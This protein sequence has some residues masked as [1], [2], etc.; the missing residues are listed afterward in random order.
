VLDWLNQNGFSLTQGS[1]NR[2][3]LTVS[4]TR[5]Q[6]EHAFGVTIDDYLM[7]T[8]QFHAIDTDPSIPAA[9]APW[10]R[11]VTGFSNLAR[12]RPALSP[13]TIAQAYNGTLT[14]G[15]A[16]PGT[17]S[18]VLPPGI[19]GAGQT[20]AVIEYDSF[21]PSDV[22]F[23]LAQVGLP[24]TL[25]NQ[26]TTVPVSKGTSPSGCSIAVANYQ[27]TYDP[28]IITSLSP[29]VGAQIGGT[30]VDLMGT[31][32]SQTM[33][34]KF[35]NTPVP[36]SCVSN[37]W[38]S[39]FSPA[40]NSQEHVTVTVN[41]ITSMQSA[42]D[43]FTYEPFPYGTMSPNT[44]S[45]LGGTVVTV[46][47]ANFSAASND[48]EFTFATGFGATAQATNVK[49]RSTTVCTITVP[50]YKGGSGPYAAVSVTANGLTSPIGEFLYNGFPQPPTP[51]P[52]KPL[53]CPGICQLLKCG[54]NCGPKFLRMAPGHASPSARTSL[55]NTRRKGCT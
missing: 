42:A 51:K 19:N 7:G 54:Q 36:V 12:P 29:N 48:T 11:S 55:K 50:A 16:L 5:G 27:F 20:I 52:V 14:P 37:T 38:C 9:L 2:L 43:I 44:G 3:T 46:T 6:A 53:P 23:W 4:G 25:I 21:F 1:D 34:V 22:S 31:G 30:S 8:R 39:V 32:F 35:G 15:G 41:G 26:V 33:T 17:G 47:E 40:G 45:Y 13:Q 18:G 28:P 24:A 10:I 49:C